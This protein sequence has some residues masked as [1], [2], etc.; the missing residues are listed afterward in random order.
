MD[1]GFDVSA[2][3]ALVGELNKA[4]LGQPAQLIANVELP[5]PLLVLSLELCL[6][7]PEKELVGL[8]SPLKIQFVEGFD[9]FLR[10]HEPRLWAKASWSQA[11][12]AYPS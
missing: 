12:C 7:G 11:V 1:F 2:V 4:A 5:L 9:Q 10:S 8:Q 3:T 6:L